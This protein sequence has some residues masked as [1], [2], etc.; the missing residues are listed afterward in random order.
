MTV[1]PH[2]VRDVM[3]H[4]AVAIGRDAGYKEIVELIEQWKVSALPVLAGEGVN[5]T[6]ADGIVTLSGDLQDRS[7]IPL[8]ARAVR[9]VEGTVDIRVALSGPP[10]R[11]G[12]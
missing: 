3:T 10:T 6:V 1:S 11:T 2:S 12:G 7:L 8:L 9:A 5:A 4:T